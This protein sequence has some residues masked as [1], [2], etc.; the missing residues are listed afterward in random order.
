MI[1]NEL[2]ASDTYVCTICF[3]TSQFLV[4]WTDITIYFYGHFES[5]GQ[6]YHLN[7]QNRKVNLFQNIFYAMIIIEDL[8]VT[9]FISP[10]LYSN[11]Q[12]IRTVWSRVSQKGDVKT[13][14]RALTY[15]FHNFCL[16]CM[17]IKII[18]LRGWRVGPLIRG[19]SWPIASFHFCVNAFV[20]RT[21]KYT[22]F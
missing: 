11:L 1:R 12:V 19:G 8:S 9:F 21:I 2:T 7:T 18:K 22:G 14:E 17:K 15:Y 10:S 13:G 3:F 4:K 6:L 16:N 20:P 5:E